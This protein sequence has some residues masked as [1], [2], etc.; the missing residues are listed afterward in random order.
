[1]FCVHLLLLA[2]EYA[3]AESALIWIELLVTVV[4][5]EVRRSASTRVVSVRG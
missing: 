5:I 3:R 2:W 1:V 4:A